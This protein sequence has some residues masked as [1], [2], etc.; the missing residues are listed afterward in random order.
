MMF[1]CLTLITF[2]FLTFDHVQPHHESDDVVFHVSHER[3][4]RELA[5]DHG[6]DYISEVFPGSNYHHAVIRKEN[7]DPVAH[8]N[9]LSSD[10]RVI[11]Y[12]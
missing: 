4:A 10:P 8:I 6:L 9:M 12:L 11:F 5:N 7:P 1:W 3:L 2:I